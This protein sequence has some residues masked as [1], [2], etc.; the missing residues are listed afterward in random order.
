MRSFSRAGLGAVTAATMAT[1]TFP[2]IIASVLAAELIDRFGIARS[3]IGL[4]VTATSLVGA[5]ASPFFG[6][7]TDR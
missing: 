6:R 1:A 2:L 3:Q 4:L 7:V 5:L